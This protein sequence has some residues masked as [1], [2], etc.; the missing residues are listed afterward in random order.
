MESIP[1]YPVQLEIV[2]LTILSGVEKPS[3]A[4]GENGL[5][6]FIEYS[7]KIL[8]DAG[9][10]YHNLIHNAAWLNV[11]L[12]KIDYGVVSHWHREHYAGFSALTKYRDNLTIYAPPG[13]VNKLERL[14]FKVVVVKET[15][16]TG[17]LA[18]LRPLYDPINDLYEVSLLIKTSK[19]PVLIVGC[20]HPGPRSILEAALEF[21]EEYPYMI[22]GGL[23][24]IDKRH[25]HEIFKI[26]KGPLCI[27]NCIGEEV[28]EILFEKYP[29][30]TCRIMPGTQ[31]IIE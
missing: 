28:K 2:T 16:D 18:I 4:I 20:G 27:S 1:T 14:G 6:V 11:N 30:R 21:A 13:I 7:K 29:D 17:E 22:V 5:S 8:F 15:I 31:I 23:G 12:S 10:K 19:G 3:K 24:R 25:V 9:A 26:V